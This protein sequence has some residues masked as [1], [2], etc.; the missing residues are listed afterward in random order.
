MLKNFGISD[1]ISV[2]LPNSINKCVN[3]K[4]I[5]RN[6]DHMFTYTFTVA[7]GAAPV[8]EHICSIDRGQFAV[9]AYMLIFQPKDEDSFIS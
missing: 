2:L 8:S 4:R 3:T 5:S 9:Q 6:V 1:M 7:T